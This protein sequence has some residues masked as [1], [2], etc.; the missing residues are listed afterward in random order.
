MQIVWCLVTLINTEFSMITVL[1][2]I[3]YNYSV[4]SYG[5][6]LVLFSTGEGSG[7]CSEPRLII[8]QSQS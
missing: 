4:P 6:H 8:L 7:E 5:Q 3:L 1:L 2:F